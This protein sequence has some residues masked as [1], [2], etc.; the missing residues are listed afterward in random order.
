M[1]TLLK[2]KLKMKLDKDLRHTM[3]K[4]SKHEIL[5]DLDGDKEPDIAILDTNHDGDID[6]FAL[7][8]DGDGELGFYV[9]DSDHNGIPDKILF[10]TDGDGKL[11]VFAAGKDVED[12]IITA[13]ALV[14]KAIQDGEYIAA[15]LDAALDEVEKEVKKTRKALKKL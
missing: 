8:L 1:G 12:A 4:G 11:D 5:I 10:D 2:L 7:D 6:T 9:V 14:E 3:L 15:Q 13:V